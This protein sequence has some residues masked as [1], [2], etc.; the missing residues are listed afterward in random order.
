MPTYDYQCRDCG[1]FDALRSVGRRDEPA[2]CPACG[3]AS[4]RV[5]AFAPRLALMASGT[6]AAIQT[7]ER[8]QHEPQ[9]S[10]DYARLRH[11]SGCGCCGGAG[12]KRGA[13]VTAPN[14]AKSAPSRRPWM[15]SH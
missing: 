9:R 13:T 15:I 5:F 10:K 1:G 6:R 7:N 11:P 8:A 12:A 2:D 14:G 4:P 3:T